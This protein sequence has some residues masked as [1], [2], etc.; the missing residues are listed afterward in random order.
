MGTVYRAHRADGQFEQEVAIKFLRGSL[1]NDLFRARFLVE[2]QI[3]AR[4]QHPNI[5]RLLDGGMTSEG[6]PYLVMEFI[7]GEPLDTYCDTNKLRLRERILLFQQVARAV[8]AAHRNLVVHR[9]LKPSNILVTS[10]GAVKLLDFGTSKLLETDAALTEIAGIT[11]SYAS[12]EQLRGDPVAT[13]ADVFSLGVV[14]FQLVTGALPFGASRSYAGSVERALRE[15]APARPETVVDDHAASVR[16]VSA[17]DLRRQVRGD[18]SSILAK[19]MAHELGQRYPSVAS[20]LDDLDRYLH[21]RPV[22]A[23]P[24]RWSY[25]AGRHVRRHWIAYA[26]AAVVAVALTS[27]G[28]YSWRQQI[29][30]VQRF[31]ESRQ[32]AKYLLFDLFDQVGRLQGSTE[33]RARMA[34]TAQQLLDRLSMSPHAGYEVRL[35]TAAGYNRLAEVFGVPGF[36]NLGDT[37]AAR[38]NLV[39][40]NTILQALAFEHGSRPTTRVEVARNRL[41]SAKIEMWLNGDTEAAARLIAEAEREVTAS[42]GSTRAPWLRVRSFLR[43]QQADLADFQERW[44]DEERVA[45]LG[46]AELSEWENDAQRRDEAP[47]LTRALHLRQLGNSV[48]YRDRVEEALEHYR[49]AES[50]LRTAEASWP[51]RPTVLHTIMQTGYDLGTTFDKLNRH[52]QSLAAF[53]RALE[54]GRRLIAIEDRDQALLR[55]YAILRQAFAQMLADAGRYTEAVHEQEAVVEARRARAAAQPGV[56]G[57]ARDLAFSLFV[58]GE[59]QSRA[60]R[61][62]ACELWRQAMER[63]E[64]LRRTGAITEWDSN[65]NVATL[66][67]RVDSCTAQ[68]RS[69]ATLRVTSSRSRER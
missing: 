60:D 39:K 40:A 33:V 2:R 54:A 18:L 37:D 56:K 38:A 30:A 55:N 42:A 21:G 34:Q 65:Q 9:D 48:Y 19:A 53:T 44:A 59:V 5:A 10:E 27:A 17:A 32:T 35:E 46:I 62:R 16:G 68:P 23:R 14:L 26:S 24:Q 7:R 31:E 66:R 51:M 6:E 25:V 41:L 36:S 50:V 1:R 52:E 61:G 11:P 47:L 64:D 12:P 43:L 69:A 28:V 20:L 8:E 29:Q 45:R 15:T 57:P 13:T 22:L 4:L 49:E 63:F 58:L 67:K 3:L